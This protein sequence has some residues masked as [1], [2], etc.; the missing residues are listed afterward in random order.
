MTEDTERR[1]LYNTA[2]VTD[3]HELVVRWLVHAMDSGFGDKAAF[4]KYLAERAEGYG[5]PD[6][7]GG[8][9]VDIMMDA[10]W[11]DKSQL[12]FRAFAVCEIVPHIDWNRALGEA[13]SRV[14]AEQEEW[15]A[16]KAARRAER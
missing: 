4:L 15:A 8:V 16:K 2:T 7:I 5:A 11:G 12:L 3:L 9:L 14:V 6:G 1:F 10:I 13:W